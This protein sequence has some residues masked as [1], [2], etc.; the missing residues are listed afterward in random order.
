MMFVRDQL[1]P[2]AVAFS[3]VERCIFA[4]EKVT[5]VKEYPGDS[6]ACVH[7]LPGCMMG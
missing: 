7:M 3:R 4:I 6:N 5:R 2:Q 1:P